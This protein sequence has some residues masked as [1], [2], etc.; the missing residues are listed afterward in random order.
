MVRFVFIH[1][2]FRL[3]SNEIF[4]V[5]SIYRREEKRQRNVTQKFVCEIIFFSLHCDV[6]LKIGDR[7]SEMTEVR[8]DELNGRFMWSFFACLRYMCDEHVLSKRK[9]RS[10]SRM[11]IVRGERSITSIPIL[12]CVHCIRFEQ[13]VLF[14][15]SWTAISEHVSIFWVDAW[16]FSLLHSIIIS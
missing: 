2:Y 1:T 3:L 4:V 12:W 11:R 15:F 16:Y 7:W 10:N 14:F 8:N 5:F 13:N 6:W 9:K